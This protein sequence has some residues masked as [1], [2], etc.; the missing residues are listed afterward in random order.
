MHHAREISGGA[1]MKLINR[2]PPHRRLPLRAALGLVDDLGDENVARHHGADLAQG[3][4]IKIADDELTLVEPFGEED[5]GDGLAQQVVHPRRGHQRPQPPLGVHQ[6]VVHVAGAAAVAFVPKVPRLRGT[7]F[8]HEPQAH[9]FVK[10][11]LPDVHHRWRGQ[12]HRQH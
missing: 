5:G 10:E 9:L 12:P 3:G 11:E 4:L 8:V 2:N 6:V 1:L 7:L